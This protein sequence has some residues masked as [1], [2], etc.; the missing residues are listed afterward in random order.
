MESIYLPSS[1]CPSV[2]KGDLSDSE[3]LGF[4]SL[5]PLLFEKKVFFHSTFPF[6]EKRGFMKIVKYGWQ[7]TVE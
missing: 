2:K 7:P 6:V 1:T 4:F 5:Y 3:I